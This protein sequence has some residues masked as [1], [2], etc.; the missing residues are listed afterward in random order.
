MKTQNTNPLVSTSVVPTVPPATVPVVP[1][2]FTLG[3]DLGDRRHFVCA[4]DAAGTVIQE[5]F[6][7]NSR[8]ALLQLMEQFPKATVALEA[9]THSPWISRFLTEQ[10]ATVL[11]A[12]PR[13]LH[14]ISRHER[15]CDQ[16]DAQ[17]LA[18]LARADAALL[19]PLEHGSAQA[20]H[21]LLGLKLR[22]ALVRSR[23][24]LINA[25]RFTLK[26]LGHTVRNPSSES[27]HKTVVKEIPAACQ[28]VVQP[29]LGVLE[30]LTAQIKS[31]EKQLVQRSRTEYPVTQRLQQIAG[32]GPLTALCFVLKI[33]D[34]K[35]FNRARDVGAY[36]GLCPRRDQ[37]GGTDKQLRITKCGDGLLRRLLVNA[38]HYV[39]GPFGPACALREHGERLAGSGSLR[40]KKRAVVAVARKLAVLLLSLWKHG[41]DYERRSSTM[42]PVLA[43]A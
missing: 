37:S 38:A 20:Q 3:L 36:L 5:G 42:P 13:K 1:G 32:V 34:P 41:Q 21:D 25:V 11:V 40:E 8:P 29:V 15:K 19:H 22:D 33:G 23:V 24:S 4:L 27:F 28:P 17:M 39:L 6:L 16:R 14:A 9:G 35:R 30:N 10:G 26:S 43:P 2:G 12:N 7:T 31:L 18:R